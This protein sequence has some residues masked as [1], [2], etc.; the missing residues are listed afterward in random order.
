VPVSIDGVSLDAWL[1][2]HSDAQ[3]R[4]DYLL[5]NWRYNRNDAI[6]FSAN[7]SDGDR[8]R[9]FYGDSSLSPR[10]SV[11]FEFE[12]SGGVSSEAIEVPILQVLSLTIGRL[13]ASV[14]AN[15]PD[16]TTSIVFNA[17]SIID[18]TPEKYGVIWWEE[19]DQ[20]SALSRAEGLPDFFGVRDV[21]GDYTW[22]QYGNGE[23]ELYDLRIDPDQLDNVADDPRYIAVRA[24]LEE[25]FVELRDQTAVN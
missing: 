20:T 18:Q 19:I 4:T 21:A 13:A 10:P 25:R 16:V 2:G 14:Q 22:I 11:L 24:R 7:P 12:H 9:L 23:R 6:T 8:V 3:K 15:V 17:L 1:L 5:E